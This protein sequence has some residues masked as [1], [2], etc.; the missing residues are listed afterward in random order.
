MVC[1]VILHLW[2]LVL[3]Y[4]V[5]RKGLRSYMARRRIVERL[6]LPLWLDVIV[7]RLEAVHAHLIMLVLELVVHELVNHWVIASSWYYL[8]HLLI[9]ILINQFWPCNCLLFLYLQIL[10]PIERFS[11]LVL[12]EGFELLIDLFEKN[13]HFWASVLIVFFILWWNAEI[14]R[15]IGL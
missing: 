6:L 14:E 8:F 4:V 7:L 15:V 10:S 12:V 5:L 13:F 3:R 1:I 2:S 9:S 11:L